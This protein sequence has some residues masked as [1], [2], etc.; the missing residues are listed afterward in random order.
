MVLADTN[1]WLLMI[2]GAAACYFLGRWAG[3]IVGMRRAQK[4][5]WLQCQERLLRTAHCPLCQTSF[6]KEEDML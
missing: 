2:L 6:L 1:A 3:I 5:L 4:Q